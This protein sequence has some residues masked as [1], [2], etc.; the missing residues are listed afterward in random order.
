MCSI[1]GFT[2][3]SIDEETLRTCFDRT[4]SRGPDMTRVEA[5][6]EGCLCFHRLAIMGLHEEGC[7]PSIWGRTCASATGSCTSSAP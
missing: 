1:M 5:A 3:L 4:K 7:S 6:G 2:K